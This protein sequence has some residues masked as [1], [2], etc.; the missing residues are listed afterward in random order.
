MDS[1]QL[2]EK[3]MNPIYLN[4]PWKLAFIQTLRYEPIIYE[5]MSI[6]VRLYFSQRKHSNGHVNLSLTRPCVVAKCQRGKIFPMTFDI[7]LSFSVFVWCNSKPLHWCSA[8]FLYLL[9]IYLQPSSGEALFCKKSQYR[10]LGNATNFERSWEKLVY[11]ER[12]Y[13]KMY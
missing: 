4:C 12:L 6:A 10:R 1:N 3:T 9:P 8:L 2:P 13:V 5:A 7:L 11:L